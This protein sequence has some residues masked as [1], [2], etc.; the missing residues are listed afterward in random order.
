M[1][2]GGATN[3]ISG[4]WIRFLRAEGPSQKQ[5]KTHQR[6]FLSHL[7]VVGLGGKIELR[8]K[9]NSRAARFPNLALFYIFR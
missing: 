3:A 2:P 9:S 1:E 6:P 8:R 4:S 5:T 7:E